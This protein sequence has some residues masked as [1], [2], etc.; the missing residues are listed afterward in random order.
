MESGGARDCRDHG[1]RQACLDGIKALAKRKEGAATTRDTAG[2]DRPEEGKSKH[3][4]PD[5]LVG[6]TNEVDRNASTKNL[7]ENN[8]AHRQDLGLG[9]NASHHG[10][11]M[12][13][14]VAHN[15]GKGECIVGQNNGDTIEKN[16]DEDAATCAGHDERN[17]LVR[18]R[19]VRGK[20]GEH[21]ASVIET[22]A[23]HAH[24]SDPGSRHKE[25]VAERILEQERRRVWWGRFFRLLL[26][27]N[28]KSGKL[29][30]DQS[31][32][33]RGTTGRGHGGGPVFGI[34]R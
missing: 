18:R 21:L 10:K 15:N 24:V 32:E 4:G 7:K 33:Q 27:K 23:K 20:C 14:G 26:G 5:V 28:T 2:D 3:A 31:P 29:E 19:C 9:H 8:E 1:S 17:D 13:N 30:Q 12:M 11:V 25:Q 6:Q 16:R 34:S 22:V